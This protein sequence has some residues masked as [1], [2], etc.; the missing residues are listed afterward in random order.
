VQVATED[1]PLPY[2]GP[3]ELEALPTVEDIVAAAEET[4]RGVRP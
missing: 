3:L 1:V 4:L 2:A